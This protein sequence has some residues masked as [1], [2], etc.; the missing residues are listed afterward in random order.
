MK[1]KMDQPTIALLTDFGQ[2]DFFVPS[3]KAVILSLNPAAR[4]IDLSH[5]VPSFDVRAAGFI[6]AAC[7]PFFPAGT[8]F[9]SVVD[10]GVGSDRRILLARTERHDFIAPDNGL[11]TRVLDRAERLELRAVTNRKFF[12]S[13]SSRTFEARD[14]MAPAAAWLSL[15]TPVAEFGPRQDGCEK[16]PLRKPLLRQG[17]V[18]GEVAY[19]D[20]F[21]NLITDIPVALVERLRPGRREG[22][23]VRVKGRAIG[24]FRESYSRG[25]RA[26]PFGLA[27]SL[28]T[29]EIA[30]RQASAAARLRA[31]I[32][33]E[34]T[35]AAP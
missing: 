1:K 8:V 14:R 22:L 13:E 3:V 6:L 27:G 4:I 34:V 7:S 20:K 9:L 35:I 29:V 25:R 32:G 16:H 28:G 10:P 31:S 23:R 33:D 5:E 17:T 30:L 21:G 24:P 12:L 2:R 11:L 18:R 26:E 19:I 15:G